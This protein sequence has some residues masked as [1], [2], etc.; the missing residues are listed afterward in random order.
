MRR[1]REKP[2]VD[3]NKHCEIDPCP[4]SSSARCCGPEHFCSESNRRCN[5]IGRM[6]MQMIAFK[7]R[8]LW[9]ELNGTFIH[10]PF[11]NLEFYLC[12]K[13]CIDFGFLERKQIC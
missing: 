3:G 4:V 1:D 2:V 6:S 7:F 9:A 5:M 13:K 8:L 10:L 11:D 12:M